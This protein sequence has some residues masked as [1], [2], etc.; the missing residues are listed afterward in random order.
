M[1]NDTALRPNGPMTD[2]PAGQAQRRRRILAEA[3][4]M[5]A[6]RGDDVQIRDIAAR[7]GVALGTA[8]RYFGSKDRLYAEVYQQWCEDRYRRLSQLVEQGST[9]TERIRLLACGLFGRYT[10]EPH[11]TGMVRHLRA[12]DDPVVLDTLSRSESATLA[13]FRQ[14]LQG[15]AAPETGTIAVIVGGIVRSAVDRLGLRGLS[16]EQARSEIGDAVTLVLE[17][18]DPTLDRATRGRG[19]RA[20]RPGPPPFDQ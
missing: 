19:S 2:L 9:N 10:D 15:V 3:A 6:E 14:A 16:I 8:Y 17:F 4:A 1:S 20:R 12:S 13:L 18:R 5:I 7:A 11:L